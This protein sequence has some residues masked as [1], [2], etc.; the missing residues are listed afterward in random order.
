MGFF[1]EIAQPLIARNVPVV[2]LR[3]KSKIAFLSNW[4]DL[5]TTD[6]EQI[7][8]WDNEYPDANAACV[9]FARPDGIWIFEVD[10]ENYYKEIE[11][12]T[13]RKMPVT[14]T[15]RSSPG[16]GHYY[17]R[18]TPASIAMGNRQGKDE[19][20]REAWSARADRR[21]CV[22]P[23]SVH[24]TSGLKYEV[25]RDTPIIDSPDWFVQWC[26]GQVISEPKNS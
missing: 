21:Y 23:G 4:T 8:K 13:E 22:S 25:I 2:P 17:F 15:V 18:H 14:F 20:G 11:K 5:A 12:Q 6:T 26:S 9:A 7:E 1:R 19:A 10:K 24:P 3:P 16:R